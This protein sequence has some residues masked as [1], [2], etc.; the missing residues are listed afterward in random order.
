M[1]FDVLWSASSRGKVCTSRFGFRFTTC[2]DFLVLNYIQISRNIYISV[3]FCISPFLP[4]RLTSYV[5]AGC[6]VTI[7]FADLHGFLDNM[8][9]SWELLKHRTAYYEFIIRGS[10]EAFLNS[11]LSVEQ[12]C[13]DVIFPLFIPYKEWDT[14]V[15]FR[16]HFKRWIGRFNILLSHLLTPDSC[17]LQW[18]SSLLE[19]LKVCG[20][21]LDKLRFVRGTDYQLGQAYT[22]D[23]YKM[24]ASVTT[25]HTIKVRLHTFP[26]IYTRS[27]VNSATLSHHHLSHQR[28]LFLRPNI[29]LML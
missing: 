10:L 9:S 7:L 5:S 14:I 26:S 16:L 23:M 8:K 28:P 11:E 3:S 19:M 27:K 29:C 2:V 25:D 4:C 20:V 6:E 21:P 12:P 24:A 22:L 15:I 17:F 1:V 13:E 18:L